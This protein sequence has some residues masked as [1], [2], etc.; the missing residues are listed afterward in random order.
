MNCPVCS[1]QLREIEKMGVAVD[2]CVGCKGI[3][4]DRGELEKLLDLA[5]SGRRAAEPDPGRRP[6]EPPV[7][8]KDD[9]DSNDDYHDRHSS[10]EGRHGRHRRKRG[11]LSEFMDIFG[12]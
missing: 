12:D 1:E 9:S 3:W 11:F 5:A 10:S 6:A 4:L 7:R 2:I 8:R